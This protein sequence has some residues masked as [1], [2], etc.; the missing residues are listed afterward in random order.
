L[1]PCPSKETCVSN[2]VLVAIVIPSLPALVMAAG[3]RV[4]VR[5]LGSSATV[6]RKPRQPQSSLLMPVACPNSL[7]TFTTRPLSCDERL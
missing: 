4:G 7:R 3:D 1:P 2:L 5:C 6:T